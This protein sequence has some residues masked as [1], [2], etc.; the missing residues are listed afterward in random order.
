[1]ISYID[2]RR[3]RGVRNWNTWRVVALRCRCTD[4]DEVCLQIMRTCDGL[5]VS[6]RHPATDP[7]GIAIPRYVART[8]QLLAAVADTACWPAT[9]HPKEEC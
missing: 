5:F 7:A 3:T 4:R 9:P 8:K 6:Y 2:L 1:M